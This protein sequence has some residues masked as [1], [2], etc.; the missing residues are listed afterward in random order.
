MLRN[1]RSLN[2]DGAITVSFIIAEAYVAFAPCVLKPRLALML[3]FYVR[4]LTR[5]GSRDQ[6]STYCLMKL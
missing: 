1:Q 5:P 6:I 4:F 2:K 3:A